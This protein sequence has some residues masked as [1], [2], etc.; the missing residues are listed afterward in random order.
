MH[1]THPTADGGIVMKEVWQ[2]TAISDVGALLRNQRIS[3][4]LCLIFEFDEGKIH[5]MRR[6][7]CYDLV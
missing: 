4:R 2:A 1:H 3:A 5:R 6:Y 7:A